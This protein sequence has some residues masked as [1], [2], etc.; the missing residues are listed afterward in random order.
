MYYEWR[1]RKTG[2]QVFVKRSMKD[3]Q[4][5]PTKE[6]CLDAGITEDEYDVAELHKFVTG[7]SFS[8]GFGQK[9]AW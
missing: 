8:K 6:E 9:G 7:G 3:Y 5:P 1:D 2:K 4:V